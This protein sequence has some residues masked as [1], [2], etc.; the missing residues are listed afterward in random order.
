MGRRISRLSDDANRVLAIASVVGA[1]FEPRLSSGRATTRRR[2]SWSSS[3]KQWPPDL[4]VE[5]PGPVTRSRFSHALVRTTLYEELSAA[6]RVAL[7]RKVAEALEAL[8][9][10]EL[11]DH[12]P[13][14]AYHWSRAGTPAAEIG[15]AVEYAARAGDRALFQSPTTRPPGTTSRRSTCSPWPTVRRPPPGSSPWCW[16]SERPQHR[17]GDAKHRETLLLAAE[18]AR[19]HGEVDV[20]VRAALLNTRGFCR[21]GPWPGRRG[22]GD[23]PGGRGPQPWAMATRRPG[24]ASSPPWAWS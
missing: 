24:L 16:P 4:I 6:R 14:L 5:V 12:L 13:A 1:E 19:R 18:L 21:H 15:R 20:L 23:R 7:H 22:E 2:Q 8:H 10:G 11:D 17:A 9:T 3:R